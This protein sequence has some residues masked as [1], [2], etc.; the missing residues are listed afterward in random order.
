MV[1][2]IKKTNNDAKILSWVIKMYN[3]NKIKNIDMLKSFI[4][5]NVKIKAGDINNIKEIK[6]VV[7]ISVL[8][9]LSIKKERISEEIPKSIDSKISHIS[10]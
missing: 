3:P 9:L 7:W 8:I 5:L 4:V 10:G 6:N 1:V 2:A